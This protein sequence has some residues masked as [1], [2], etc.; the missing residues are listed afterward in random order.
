MAKR[1]RGAGPLLQG[2]EG[3]TI[4]TV[5]PHDR[6]GGAKPPQ[7]YSAS[8]VVQRKNIYEVVKQLRAVGGSGVLVSPVTYIFDEEPP[9]WRAL[10]QTLGLSDA[11]VEAAATKSG[12]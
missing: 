10:L 6:P 2:L 11:D 3:P 9:R 8:L 5:Y 1:L 7:V 4:G 12:R